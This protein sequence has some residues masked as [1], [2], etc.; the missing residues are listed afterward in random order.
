LSSVSSSHE[1][2]LAALELREPDRVPSLDLM[3]DSISYEIIGR[4]P[5]L[6]DRLMSEPRLAPV[7]DQW[8]P[9]LR[10]SPALASLLIDRMSDSVVEGLAWAAPEAAVKA[11]LDS[12]AVSYLPFFRQQ[13]SRRIIDIFGR[14]YWVT[15]DKRGFLALPTYMGGLIKS[16]DDW[17]A[18]DKKPLFRLPEK[19]NSAYS[20]IQAEYGNRVFLFGVVW[21]LFECAWEPMGFESFVVASR[22]EKDFIKRLIKFHTDLNCSMIE[23]FADAGL[24]G[25]LFT[26]DL[27]YKSGPMLN[28][29]MLEELFGDGYRRITET[30][31]SLG[32]KIVIH[33]C[34]NTASLL[35]WMAD[36]GFDGVHPLEPTAGVDLAAAKEAVGDRICLIGN[37][38]ISHVLVNGSKEEVFEAV[39]EAIADA[40]KGGGYILAAAH[41]HEAV[42]VD[43][44]RW[45]LDADKEYGLYPLETESR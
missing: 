28:P 33:S 19:C 42:T 7:L 38:D 14:E 20:R 26:D 36:C 34:G 5:S 18:W 15:V 44:L 9:L 16:P 3:M 24:P 43:R 35:P 10:K 41:S 45:M 37:I 8:V 29:R 22:K 32:M 6:T 1:R 25:C 4:R 13:D 27:A 39:R 11:G 21:G 31:H 40:G 2:V 23:A 12:V 30:A 17:Q